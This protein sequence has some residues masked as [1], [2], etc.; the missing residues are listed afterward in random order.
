[1]VVT[2][3]RFNFGAGTYR[4]VS[5]DVN[6]GPVA[7]RE[8]NRLGGGGAG[9]ERLDGGADVAAREVEALAQ[10][11]RCRSMTH[12]KQEKMHVAGLPRTYDSW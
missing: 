5:G 9:G 3:E 2:E 11:N 6:L 4:I 1:M 7:G 8:H 10:L 12:A